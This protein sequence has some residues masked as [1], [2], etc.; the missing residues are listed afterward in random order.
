[1]YNNK[2]LHNTNSQGYFYFKFPRGDMKLT[3]KISFECSKE[4]Y[5]PDAM[6]I[7]MRDNNNIKKILKQRKNS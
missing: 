1:M 5:I 4:N 3:D 7:D 6:I 2:V